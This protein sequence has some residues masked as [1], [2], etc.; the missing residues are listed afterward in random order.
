MRHSD[1]IV[2]KKSAIFYSKFRIF[3]AKYA[4]FFQILQ[5][6]DVFRYKSLSYSLYYYYR[7]IISSSMRPN[8]FWTFQWQS[9]YLYT[10]F[11]YICVFFIHFYTFISSS[12][13]FQDVCTKAVQ[14]ACWV[15]LLLIYETLGGRLRIRQKNT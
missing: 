4:L 2:L 10:F 12:I 7:V 13:H 6:I 14:I 15:N 11:I 3:Y 5:N 1:K 8:T 9:V